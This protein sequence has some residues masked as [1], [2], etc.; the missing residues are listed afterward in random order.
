[1]LKIVGFKAK[2]KEV[3]KDLNIAWLKRFFYVEDKDFE[4]LDESEKHILQKGGYIFIGLW[5]KEPVSCYALIKRKG[6][7]FE[8]GKMAVNENFQGLKIGQQMLVHAID[9]GKRNRWK[10]I[11]LYSSTKLDTAIHIYKKYGFK[12]VILENNSPY[13]RSDIKMELIL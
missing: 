8:L 6:G 12:E 7:I 9:F 2:Y 11:E 3:F 10:K 1:M 5:H 13:A 4:L